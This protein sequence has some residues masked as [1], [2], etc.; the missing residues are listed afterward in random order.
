MEKENRKMTIGKRIVGTSVE[1]SLDGW[2]DTQSA[3]LLASTIEEVG[4]EIDS[5]VLDLTALEYIS[6]A[7]IR[8][9]VAVHKKMKGALILKHVS[10]EV[11]DVIRMTGLDKK[12]HI[13]P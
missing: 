10:T 2:M 8:Q 11:M 4:S 7:G 1:L 6:S 3:P 9:I 12:L 5:L 13:E